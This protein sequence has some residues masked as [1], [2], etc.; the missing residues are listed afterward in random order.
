[1]KYPELHSSKLE[2]KIEN[3]TKTVKKAKNRKV[4][5]EC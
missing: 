1:M 4:K 5:L 3:K 2:N